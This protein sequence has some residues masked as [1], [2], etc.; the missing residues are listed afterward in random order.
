MIR[1]KW[2][3]FESR[4]LDT[5]ELS[6]FDE[7][8]GFGVSVSDFAAQFALVRGKRINL[9]LNSP[10]GSVTDGMA[11]Y[12]I[13][14]SEREKL[15]VEV[16]GLAASMASVVALAGSSLTMGEGSYFMIHNPWTIALGDA[17]QLRHDADILDKMRSELIS[18]YAAHSSL[19]TQRIAELMDAETWM[20]ADEALEAGFASAVRRGIPAAALRRDLE[21]LGFRNLP[22]PL[23]GKE[24]SGISTIRDYEQFLRDAG[25]SR[26]EAAALAS[27]GWKALHRDGAQPDPDASGIADLVAALHEQATIYL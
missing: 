2:F 15:S 3:S 9:T 5:A 23:E 27:S 6:I 25:A 14:A 20:T 21:T 24:F 1:T 8:G 26:S 16:I 19:G 22:T 18:I 7:I 11:I 13:L 12:N 4:G 17:D 10:G